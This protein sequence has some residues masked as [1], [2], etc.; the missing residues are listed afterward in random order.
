MLEGM[1][2]AI[3]EGIDQIAG[4]VAVFSATQ[5][6]GG[7]LGNAIFGAYVNIKTQEHL[8]NLTAQLVLD[9]GTITAQNMRGAV[10]MANMEARILAYNDLFT[11]IWLVVSV[12]FILKFMVWAYRRYHKIDVLEVEMQKL[13]A[14]LASDRSQK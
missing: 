2:R 14:Y 5:V 7:L 4:F 12:L 6:L 1:V 11:A 13:Q 8:S 9:N 10:Q 3:A